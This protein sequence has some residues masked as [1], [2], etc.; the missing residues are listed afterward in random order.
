VAGSRTTIGR[1]IQQ[2]RLESR[3]T[4]IELAGRLGVSAHTVRSWEQDK[5]VPRDVFAVADAL[6]VDRYW[7]A[8]LR[9]PTIKWATN[10]SPE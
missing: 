10:G 5:R 2:A 1:R 9:R 8:G 6:G 7:L 3:I 4:R